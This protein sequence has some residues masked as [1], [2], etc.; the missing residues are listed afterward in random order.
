MEAALASKTSDEWWKAL[1]AAGVPAGPVYTVPEALAH[2]QIRDRGMVATFENAP[3]VGRDIRLVRTGFKVNG[4]APSV[5]KPPPQLGEHTREI[6]E[7]L[8]YDSDAI[9]DMKETHA[10]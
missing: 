1:N 7:E 4:E 10:I 8:G 6:L 2:P 5:D 9:R 3:G